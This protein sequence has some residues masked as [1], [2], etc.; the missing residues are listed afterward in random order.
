MSFRIIRYDPAYRHAVI[1]LWKECN[2][3]VPQNDPVVDIQ[4]KLDFQPQLFFIALLNNQLIGSVMV[5]YDGHRGWL[6]YLAISTRHQR[7][8]Y[9]REL[10]Q[11]AIEELRKLGCQKLNV[12]VRK[13]NIKAIE[14]YKLVGFKEDNVVNLG[15]RLSE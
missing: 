4:K 6:N 11:K 3:I 9:G 7:Q 15:K 5:G 10:V 14:F 13:S 8:G 12:Q 2:I 1:D